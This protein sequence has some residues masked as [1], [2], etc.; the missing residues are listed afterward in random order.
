M[1]AL[2]TAWNAWRHKSGKD[3]VQE[4]KEIGFDCIE[5]N[6]S[7]NSAIVE[8]IMDLK[9][10][11]QIKV[12]S[13]HNFCPIPNGTSR[14]NAS[15]D[16]FSLSSL[17]EAERKKAVDFT[18]KTI[19]TAS[20]LGAEV[21]VLHLGKV[22]MEEK[23]KSLLPV[24]KSSGTAGLNKLKKQMFEERR[25]K[26]KNFFDQALKSLEQLCDYAQERKVKLGIENRYY[27]SEIPAVEEMESI[28][29]EF[30]SPPIYYWHDVGHAQVYEN[31]SLFKHKT[32]LDKFAQRM[33]GI[34]LHDI[35]GIDDHR[36]PLKGN[37]D[38]SI[39]KPYLKK[40]TLKVLE[41]HQ[42][43]TAEDIIYARKYLEELFADYKNN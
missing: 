20:D 17:D 3:I 42:P 10:R 32:M 34:H 36:A 19:D 23:I 33:V 43:A 6:F 1:F 40:E 41:P 25:K 38:F 9:D 22:K 11:G 31:L 4:I 28:L 15:P 37:F 7:L 8:E 21:A 2:S 26:A 14:Q 24:F 18:R 13:V 35:E 30:P 16:I 39:L 5:L 12:V 29:S 27:F